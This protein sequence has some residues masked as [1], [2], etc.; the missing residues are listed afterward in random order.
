MTYF[1][2]F[3]ILD[4]ALLF[5][6]SESDS[7]KHQMVDNSIL[8]SS[9]PQLLHKKIAYY[10]CMLIHCAPPPGQDIHH[11]ALA[12][13][14]TNN[15]FSVS[16]YSLTTNL[17]LNTLTPSLCLK[18]PWKPLWSYQSNPILI[19]NVTLSMCSCHMVILSLLKMAF[20]I[21]SGLQM[22]VVSSCF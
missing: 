20:Q 8:N 4:V 21:W 5:K 16:E 17:H 14:R 15:L 19:I 1:G 12:R 22:P 11:Y 2:Q 18:T 9:S 3:L 6:M 13:A 10:C 7:N